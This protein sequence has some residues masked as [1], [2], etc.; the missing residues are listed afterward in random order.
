MCGILPGRLAQTEQDSLHIYVV[1]LAEAFR[2]SAGSGLY[3]QILSH[4]RE[5]RHQTDN[6][7]RIVKGSNHRGRAL[8]ARR[9]SDVD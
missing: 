2:Y 6:T 5:E 1:L 4:L 8:T 7:G 9:F 3:F